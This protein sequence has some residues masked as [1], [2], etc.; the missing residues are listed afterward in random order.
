MTLGWDYVN[1]RSLNLT[2]WSS[3]QDPSSGNFTYALDPRL[4]PQVLLFKGQDIVFRDGPY[5]GVRL[6]GARPLKDYAVFRPNYNVNDTHVYA[7]FSN[8]DNSTA[9]M[10]RLNPSSGSPELLR[11]NQGRGEWVNVYSVQKD[12]CDTY[13]RCGPNGLCD[14][15]QNRVCECPTGFVPKVPEEWDQIDSSGGC[16]LKTRLNCSAS[17]GFKKFSGLKLPYGEF[18]V[19]WTVV[20]NDE[21][22]LICRRNCSCVAY[23]VAR[24]GGCVVW[25]GDMLDMRLF[26]EGGQD[27][28]IRMAASEFGSHG[29][30]KR[31]AVIISVSVVSGFVVLFLV[32]WY[33]LRK[34]TS[35]RSSAS[36]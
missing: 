26:S 36:G 21:C 32:G 8:V 27:L 2:S 6:G 33:I 31:T 23:A 25:S 24:V 20:R 30:G 14:S 22:E 16:V 4:L 35:R 18:S 1:G 34:R 19:N 28:Y 3:P 12:E 15:S 29:N 17:E 10:F 7:T 13:E 5:D 11:W 9:N